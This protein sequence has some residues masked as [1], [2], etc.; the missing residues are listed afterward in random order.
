MPTRAKL[1]I[2]A[3]VVGLV[4]ALVPVVHPSHSV[5]AAP[6]EPP[7]QRPDPVITLEFAT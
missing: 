2:A 4:A 6:V 7:Q 5:E 3:A 1:L